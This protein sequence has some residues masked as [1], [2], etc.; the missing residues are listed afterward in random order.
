MKAY[1]GKHGRRK[2]WHVFFQVEFDGKKFFATEGPMTKA[3]ARRV[4]AE[5]KKGAA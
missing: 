3:E 5:K 4:K 1:I 2:R